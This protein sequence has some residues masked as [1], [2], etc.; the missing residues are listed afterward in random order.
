MVIFSGLRSGILSSK[1]ITQ[2]LDMLSL[3]MRKNANQDTNVNELFT[4]VINKWSE[5]T[6]PVNLHDLIHILDPRKEARVRS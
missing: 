1:T 4:I 5:E 3:Y 2:P 6:S